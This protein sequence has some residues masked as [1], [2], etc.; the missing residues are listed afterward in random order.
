MNKKKLNIKSKQKI[1]RQLFYLSTK[2]EEK[3]ILSTNL[4]VYLHASAHPVFGTHI[5][6]GSYGLSGITN[7]D[8]QV[9]MLNIYDEII[10]F[11]AFAWIWYGSQ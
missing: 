5:T 10:S 9:I 7:P 4:S 6:L 8:G 3:C 11:Y 1:I 2:N